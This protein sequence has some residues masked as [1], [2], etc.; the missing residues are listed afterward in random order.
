MTNQRVTES[1]IRT[2]TVACTGLRGARMKSESVHKCTGQGHC[3][4]I[5]Q[6]YTV[7]YSKK[8]R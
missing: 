7:Q 1:Q 8:N 2:G 6:D 5:I 4:T 3:T